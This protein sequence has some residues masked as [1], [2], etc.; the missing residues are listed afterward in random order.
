[1][2]VFLQRGHVGILL[3]VIRLGNF[4]KSLRAIRRVGELWK[5][6]EKAKPPGTNQYKHRSPEATD[7]PTL[8]QLGISKMQSQ[9]MQAEASIPEKDSEESMVWSGGSRVG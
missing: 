1:V 6:I 8:K 5:A 9:D 2:R 7:P 4:E 3:V